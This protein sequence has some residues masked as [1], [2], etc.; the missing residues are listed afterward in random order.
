[1]NGTSADLASRV[2][3][4]LGIGPSGFAAPRTRPGTVSRDDLVKQFLLAGSDTVIVVTAPGGYGKTTT[5]RLWQDAD[6]RRFAWVN[7]DELD[8]DPVRLLRHIAVSL[9]EVRP[10]A[11][12]TVRKLTGPGRS[13]EL[14]MLPAL[15]DELC[16]HDPCV[17]VLDDVHLLASDAALACVTQLTAAVPEGSALVLVGRSVP[18]IHLPR[19]RMDSGVLELGADDLAMSEAEATELLAASGL[20]LDETRV[21]HL[22]ERTEGWPGGLH[23]A[24]LALRGGAADEMFSGAHRLVAD[25][26]VDEVLQGLS[27][28][29]VA[30]L[31]RSSVLRSMNAALLDEVLGTDH[32]GRMLEQLEQTGNLFLVPLD[33]HRDWYRYH[34]LFGELLHSRLRRRDPGGARRLHARA[35]RILEERGDLAAAVHH[36]VS[37][38]DTSRAA[39]L[40]LV[41][42]PSL[43][44]SGRGATV[45]ALLGTLG[46]DAIDRYPAAAIA[47]AWAGV[48][49]GDRD[50]I[51]RAVRSAEASPSQGPLADGSPSVS[52]AVAMVRAML[53]N[54]GIHGVIRNCDIVCDSGDLDTNPWWA[55][56]T[57]IKG[58]AVSMLGD[59]ELAR[60]L[61][62]T[63]Q[64]HLKWAHGFEAALEA[65][66]ALID[67]DTG[68]PTDAEVHCAR[69]LELAD[70]HELE[71]VMPA[72]VVFA[73]GALLAAVQGHAAESA[74]LSAVTR[75]MLD[76]LGPLSP[77]T[78]LLCNLALARASL[79]LGDLKS[80]RSCIRLAALA[81][82]KE[83]GA[84]KLSRQLEELKSRLPERLS[85]DDTEALTPAELRVLPY[86]PTHLSLQEIAE[87]LFISR[88][89]AKTHSVAIYRKLG[90]SSRGAAVDT[91]RRLGLLDA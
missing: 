64:P 66:L 54:G 71:G 5:I 28:D 85:A 7:L 40:V 17:L 32:S 13:A 57:A 83:P 3:D 91:A 76:R 29:T 12:T 18:A 70:R 79:A 49:S 61:F 63:A 45:V 86:L 37:A 44:L 11:A 77:R 80:V 33:S 19:R 9:D 58:T 20:D 42:A 56:A 1:V 34:H 53:A 81:R 4:S 2:R 72:T 14:D 25:Y 69:A 21:R 78:A 50:Q 43:T 36:A 87:Q 16:R 27:D 65:H 59:V 26:L 46:D 38:G 35:G 10:L 90:V 55:M 47:G 41:S 68:H 88:N 15:S 84:V 74:R 51:D 52:V 22:V 6:E 75:R 62:L 24:A 39:D 89:T 30:F 48:T 60:R 8:N 31:E 73:T 67:L 82:E 23:L